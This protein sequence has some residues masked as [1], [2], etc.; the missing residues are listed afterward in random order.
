MLV[1]REE[2]GQDDATSS[3]AP[4]T[5]WGFILIILYMF[6]CMLRR[7]KARAWRIEYVLHYRLPLDSSLGWQSCDRIAC[8]HLAA[9]Q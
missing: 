9:W 1:R 7:V 8:R 5:W 6:A 2:A 4:M 3:H